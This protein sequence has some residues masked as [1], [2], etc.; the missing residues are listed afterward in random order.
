MLT[1]REE[2]STCGSVSF[3]SLSSLQVTCSNTSFSLDG[4]TTRIYRKEEGQ[5]EGLPDNFCTVHIVTDKLIK[6]RA[7]TK[8]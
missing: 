4:T 8:K 7:S 5:S 1:S 3:S 2:R 6:W